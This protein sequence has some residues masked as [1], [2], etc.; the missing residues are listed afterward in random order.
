MRALVPLLCVLLAGSAAPAAAD[1]CP[2]GPYIVF[3]EWQSDALSPESQQVLADALK[4][5]RQCGGTRMLVSGHSDTSEE[6]GMDMA[7]ARAVD[8][9]LMG[10]GIAPD[11]IRVD[12]FGASRPRIETGP[13]IR[14]IQNRRVEIIY[15]PSAPEPLEQ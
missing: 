8:R 12:A 6:P 7:R 3:F 14:E 11:D 15:G 10:H 13:D 4:R 2:S 9:W 1:P 5:R